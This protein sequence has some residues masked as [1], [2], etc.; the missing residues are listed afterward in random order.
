M[1]DILAITGPIYITIALGFATTRLGLFS[2]SDMRVL[3]QFVINLALPALL[4]N[5]LAQRPL[6]EILNGRYLLVYAV[7]SLLALGLGWLW[8]RRVAGQDGTSSAYYAM[9]MSCPNSGFVGYPIALLTLGPVAGVLLGLNMMVENLLLIPL[10][11]ALAERG[12]GHGGAWHRALRQSLGNLLRNPMVLGLLAGLLVSLMGWQLPSPV[13][14]TVTLFSQ[15]SGALSLF[16]IGGALVGLQ[17]QG[18]RRQ[19]AQIAAGKLLLHPLAVVAVLWLFEAAGLMPLE[20]QLRMGLVLTAACPM[21][22]IYPILAQKH[23]REGLA[24]AALL[25]ATVA[26]FVSISVLLWV[27]QQLPGWGR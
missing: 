2:K 10:L 12:D 3:G 6:G 25:G 22:G 5:A 14:R 7:G 27:F 1:L 15:A 24:A 4:F 16:V 20:P 13:A 11:L 23:G 21:L 18:M 9:G 26:S 19:V 8:A 17:I